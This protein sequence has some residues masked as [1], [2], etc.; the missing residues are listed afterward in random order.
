MAKMKNCVKLI[1]SALLCFI[2]LCSCNNAGNSPTD[3]SDAPDNT[4]TGQS[5]TLSDEEKA[6]FFTFETEEYDG[7]KYVYIS[8]VTEE[9]KKQTV[10]DVPEKYGDDTVYGFYEGC[11]EGCT[12]L[13]D[14]YVHSNILEWQKNLFPGCTSLKYIHMDY[15]D[16]VKN[17]SEETK[18][19]FT[20]AVAF[21]GSVYGEGSIV[22]GMKNVNFVFGDSDT[23][24]YFYTDY[25][26]AAY[27]DIYVLESAN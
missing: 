13:T 19:N 22:S 21:D 24:N 14:V 26:W 17:A 1:L 20:G 4:Q 15:S 10:L 2:L 7:V 25:N 9:G 5:G 23:Y 11:F 6:K 3:G 27:A 16:F 18:E 12:A 8:G